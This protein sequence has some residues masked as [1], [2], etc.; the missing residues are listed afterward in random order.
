MKNCFITAINCIDGRVQEP[1]TEYLKKKY[2]ADYVDMV[3]APGPNKILAEGDDSGSIVNL[4]N[5]VE[6]SMKKHGSKI[7]AVCAH[8][9]CA[10]NPV[11]EEQQKKHLLQA[12]EVINTWGF[13]IRVILLWIDSNWQVNGVRY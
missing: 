10:G 13:N 2:K 5:C 11:D 1:V 4:R 8:H 6:I 7:L 12:V 9:D 3:T